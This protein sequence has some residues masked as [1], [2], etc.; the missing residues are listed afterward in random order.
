MKTILVAKEEFTAWGTTYGVGQEIPK[1]HA[2][3]WPDGTL[4]NRLN[5]GMAAYIPVPED[6]DSIVSVPPATISEK[7]AELQGMTKAEIVA[8]G[9]TVGLDLDIDSRKDDLIAAVLAVTA[10]A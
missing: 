1:A 6:A 5:S 4:A 10:P 2:D 3:S 8:Y 7:A 9:A